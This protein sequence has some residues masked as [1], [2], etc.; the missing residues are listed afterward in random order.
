MV[1]GFLSILVVL[2]VPVYNSLQTVQPLHLGRTDLLA[3]LR[4]AQEKAQRGEHD[5]NF[6]IFAASNTFILYRGQS[7]ATRVATEDRVVS[8][9]S[10]VENNVNKE[11]NFSK[12]SGLPNMPQIFTLTHS[13]AGDTEIVTVDGSGLIY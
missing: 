10:N 5:S 11:V 13:F 6:G 3:H 1:I 9:L 4:L 8:F 7:Y 2:S 12:K